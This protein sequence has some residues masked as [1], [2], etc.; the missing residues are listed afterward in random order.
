MAEDYNPPPR[1]DTSNVE[2]KEN[3]MG[4]LDD[5]PVATLTFLASIVLI[6]I[7]YIGDDISLKDAFAALGFAGG[8]SGAI[9]YVRNQAGRGTRKSARV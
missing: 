8:G 1:P 4:V 2:P 7:G 5:V 6:V 9:G 3:G